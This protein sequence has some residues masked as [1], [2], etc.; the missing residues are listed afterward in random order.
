MTKNYAVLEKKINSGQQVLSYDPIKIGFFHYFFDER[1]AGV[2]RVIA[3]NIKAFEEFY[4]SIKPILIAEEFQENLFEDY[5]R[6]KLNPN[7]LINDSRL[8]IP[9]EHFLRASSIRNSLIDL[10]NSFKYGFFGEN[11]LR[12]IDPS[13]TKG[14]RNFSEHEKV[15]DIPI[16]Y[17]NH[18]FFEDYPDDWKMFLK[19]FDDVRDP[20]PKSLNVTQIGLTSSM[21][22]KLE[23]FFDGEAEV[24]R[25][26][27][28]CEDFY[29]K[30]DG[31]DDALRALF[32]EKG[33]VKSGEKIIAYPVRID[34]RKNIEEALFITKVLNEFHEGNYRLIVTATRDKDYKKPE[35]NIYQRRIE[36]FAKECDIPC[37]L[38]EAYE[39]IDGKNFNIGNLYHISDLAL[40]TAVKEGFG[41]A[42]V[43]P[44]VSGTPLIGRRIREV[45]EDFEA[46]GMSFKKNLYDSSVLRAT[47]NWESRL[48]KLESLLKNKVELEETVKRLDLSGRIEYAKDRVEKNARIVEKEYSYI[49]VIKNVIKML[50]LPGYEKLE[51][52]V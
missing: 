19:G 42:Y 5:E 4:P 7:E 16:I 36:K 1:S 6:I 34:Q 27:V 26:S 48:K 31:K 21:Q 38:G 39:Y 29:K 32:E 45:C 18:D 22:N 50:K 44:W 10:K 33:I 41:Y 11:I 13:V 9:E 2:N 20:I 15:S 40:T 35:D 24:L 51:K 8:T 43:E 49:P 30:N 23:N 47:R 25:N 28:V 3:N 14:V 17:R 12:G 37:S 46:H 52:V